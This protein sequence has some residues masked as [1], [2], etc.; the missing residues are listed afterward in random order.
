MASI[1][2]MVAQLQLDTRNFSAKLTEASKQ[3]NAFAHNTNKSYG[4]ATAAL[5]SHTMEL[6]STARIVQ[7]IMVSQ[8]FY[9]VARGIREA[10]ASLLQFNEELDYMQVTYS[11]LFG[12]TELAQDFMKTL[13]EHSI[14]TIFEFGELADASKKLLAYGIEYENLMFVMEGLTNLGAMSGDMA[15]IERAARAIGQ[16]FTKGTLK[17]EEM[18]QLAD[19]YIPIY[20][21]VQSSFGL[22]D[23]QMSKVGDLKLPAE[24]VINA[25]IDYANSE[26]GSVADAAMMTITGLKNRIVDTFKVLGVEMLEP[27]TAAFK[28]FLVFV[29]KNLSNLREIFKQ[30]GFGGIFETLVP[31]PHVQKMLRR[32]VANVQ[33][34]LQALASALK[35]V[36]VVAKEIFTVFVMA[37]NAIQPVL[38]SLLNIISLVLYNFT[39][40]ATGAFILRAAA[41][42][43]AAALAILVI[44]TTRAMVVSVLTAMVKNLSKALMILSSVIS[45]L[46]KH[47][48][49][50]IFMLLAAGLTAAALSSTKANN[51]LSG[52]FNTL[53]VAGTN[54]Y[55]DVFKKTSNDIDD[56]ASA[57][58]AFNNRLGE[59]KDAADALGDGLSGAS[60]KAKKA[61]KS[62][63]A[64]DEVFRLNEPDSS[65]SGTGS[66]IGAG[67]LDDLEGLMSGL[68]SL[69]DGLMPEIP[70]FS[71]YINGFTDGLFGGLTNSLVDAFSSTIGINTIM[72]AITG[73]LKAIAKMFPIAFN[74]SI[75]TMLKSFKAGSL[76]GFFKNI[77]TI[78]TKDGL[79]AIAK[80]GLIGAAI[81]MVMDGIAALLWNTLADKFNLSAKAEGNAKVGQTI[82]SILGTI[83]GGL[84]GGPPGAMIGSAIGTF[85]GGFIG[86][87]WEKI[88]EFL[89]PAAEAITNFAV[90]TARILGNWFIDTL[91][92]FGGWLDTT[93]GGFG[94]WF[95]NT[96]NGI[97]GWFSDTIVLFT[98]WS[99]ING[100]TLSTWW[101]NT[102]TGISTWWTDTKNGFGNWVIDTITGFNDWYNDTFG[103]FTEWKDK[104]IETIGGWVTSVIQTIGDWSW[105]ARKAIAD[106]I[107]NVI[108]DFLD[109]ANDV[110][111]TLEDWK[112][113]ALEVIGGFVL[114][115][116]AAFVDW[117]ADVATEISEWFV[118]L[119]NDVK[120]WWK[121]LWDPSKW[122]TGW[123]LV[124][125]WFTA[126][127]DAISLW[128]GGTFHKAV[129]A[130][131]KALWD[132]TEWSS[133]WSLIKGWFSDLL[134][135]IAGWMNDVASAISS[136]WSNLWSDKKASVNVNGSGYTSGVSSGSSNAP[137]RPALLA[138]DGHAYGGIFNREHIARFAEGNKAEMVVPLENATAMQPFVDAISR[139]ILEGLAPTLL[140]T[141]GNNDQNLPP[142]YVGTLIADERGIKQL[143]K[144]FQLIQIQEN[145]RRGITT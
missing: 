104:I 89:T 77:A 69:G 125:S 21:I 97:A 131:W 51:A 25:I 144:K 16:I 84:M 79:K 55:S 81:G 90:E 47:P 86:L 61:S 116:L 29:D 43:A 62:L 32:F 137:P 59:G 26:F 83:I 75:G 58:D 1:S 135:G 145:A 37:F 98:D 95:T 88:K 118:D 78:F 132:T 124:L 50:I 129:K 93:F 17:A 31:D 22:T 64:F 7:G 54:D 66:G 142:M 20:E 48:I 112:E 126:I 121:N 94:T 114:A 49:G 105:N 8:A 72:G 44:Q 23:Q 65:T 36:G 4:K 39:Q 13:Q 12:N 130:L 122:S 53:A 52:L 40:T 70:D 87:F 41:L 3:M 102:K 133:G 128:F 38:T 110:A 106:W 134:T 9:T 34:L 35:L 140:Q 100:E 127:V 45:I 11:A 107:A 60:D 19:A 68:G 18:K 103:I 91:E 143:Y 46:A 141:G 85:T 15:A 10:T 14:N 30:S 6:K 111:E 108:D 113:T 101:T 139:G 120:Q 33:N 115:A 123:S 76:A 109:W 63:L 136:W 28:S 73:M 117:C 67:V 138:L 74:G 92:L 42:A 5:R 24:D 99:N 27:L 82:G 80:G 57:A 56:A 2:T 119:I 71:E 96:F